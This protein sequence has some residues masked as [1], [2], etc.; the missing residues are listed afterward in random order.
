MSLTLVL[1][2]ETPATLA[3]IFAL[4]ACAAFD[5]SDMAR[6]EQPEAA[7]RCVAWLLGEDVKPLPR[8][9]YAE[10]MPYLAAHGYVPGYYHPDTDILVQR[11]FNQYPT[12]A[13]ELAHVYGATESEAESVARRGRDCL[14]YGPG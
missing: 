13:H 1:R 10:G 3:L 4:S 6:L 2:A 12:L 8:I 14:I 7:N 9:V 5:D 11:R